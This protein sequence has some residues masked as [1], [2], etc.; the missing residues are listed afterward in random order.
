LAV[1]AFAVFAF[2]LQAGAQQNA[3]AQQ[4]EDGLIRQALA[5][6]QAGRIE[7]AIEL[8]REACKLAPANPY[9]RLYL[10]LL[11]YQTDP[12]SQEA[13]DLM[14][15]VQDKFPTNPDLILRLTDSYLSSGKE[16]QVP[17][18]LDRSRKAIE[19]NPRLAMSVVYLLVRY[20]QLEQ[21]RKELEQVSDR[22]QAGLAVGTEQGRQNPEATRAWGE[23][24]FLRGLI[25]ATLGQ[26][27]EAMQQFQAADRS[28]FPPQDSP[29]MKMLAEAL[30]RLEENA[31]SAQA[32]RVY[33]SHFPQDYEARFRLGIV[34]LSSASFERAEDQLRQVRERVPAM[35][36]VSCYLGLV[37]VEMKKLDEARDCFE[38]ELKINPA[39]YQ[40]MTQ[41]A[42]LEYAQG[43][44]EKCRTW[45]DKAAGLNPD[46][47]E[48]LYVYGLLYNRLRE[49]D[50]A[51]KSLER[52]V[53]ENPTHIKA[54]FQLSIAYR[55][56][57]NEA[58]AREHAD[59]YNQLLEAHRAK[60]LGD[61]PRRK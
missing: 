22:V 56:S 20:A 44:L 38:S 58:K 33:L 42:Y 48:M 45:L 13:Q 24:L 52:V 53:R 26:K 1:L 51:V 19:S 14:V 25:A 47:P 60:T 55:R 36:E 18:L 2:V 41:L 35:A 4:T 8:L 21:A 23:V 28:E 54:H 34:Y 40:A 6:Y 9:A 15:S 46:W 10:G 16:E 27:N 50:K 29:Q 31:L 43:D 30:S 49:Y 5:E 37:L 17:P 59:I 12:S 11:V 3:A 32:Y 7:P 57:G 61:D 39:S